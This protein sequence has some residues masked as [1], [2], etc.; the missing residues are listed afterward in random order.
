MVAA[1]VFYGIDLAG[2]F[3]WRARSVENVEVVDANCAG[4]LKLRVTLASKEVSLSP[5]DY[6]FLRFPQ[7]SFWNRTRFPYRLLDR[8]GDLNFLIK[9]MGKGSFT[10][11]L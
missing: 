8:G 4:A 5:G 1:V 10:D 2:R 3:L 9:G 6:M 7:I 11:R